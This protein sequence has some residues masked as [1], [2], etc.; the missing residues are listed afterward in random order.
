MIRYPYPR[1]RPFHEIHAAKVLQCFIPKVC[2]REIFQNHVFAKKD[3]FCFKNHVN[4]S[5]LCPLVKVY[6]CEPFHKAS[7]VCPLRDKIPQD[8]AKTE[9]FLPWGSCENVKKDTTVDA[10]VIWLRILPNIYFDLYPEFTPH[11]TI[12]AYFLKTSVKSILFSSCIVKE[13][14]SNNSCMF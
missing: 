8:S 13:I 2:S 4:C 11:F 6:A 9:S 10:L 5:S 1:L 3:I 7:V 12:F 14:K